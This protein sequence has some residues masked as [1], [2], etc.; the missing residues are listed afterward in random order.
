MGRPAEGGSS[1]SGIDPQRLWDLINSLKNRAGSD[2][3][4]GAPPLVAGWRSQ[5]RRLGLDTGG[6]AALSRHFGWAQDQLP[7]LRQRHHLAVRAARPYPSAG[8][9]AGVDDGLVD[10]ATPAEAARDALAAVHLAQADPAAL[11]GDRFRQLNALLA[12]HQDNPAFAEQFATGLGPAATLAFYTAVT[13]PRQYEDGPRGHPRPSPDLTARRARLADLE[14]ALGATL[15]TASRADTSAMRRWQQD[16]IDLG[17]QDVGDNSQPVHGFQAMSALMRHGEYDAGFLQRYGA[18]L[19]RFEKRNT[20]DEVGGLQHLV[21]RKDVLPWD[22]TGDGV[23]LHYGAANDGGADPMTGFMEALGR[24]PEASTAF[25]TSP[26]HLDYLTESRTWPAD[27]A[28][29]TAKTVAGYAAL[30]HALES[31]TMGAPYDADPPQLHRTAATAAILVALVTRFGRSAAG[32]STKKTRPSGADLLTRE[33]PLTPSLGRITAAY[34]DDVDWALARGDQFSVFAG[35]DGGRESDERALFQTAPLQLFLGTIGH[36]DDAYRSVTN[37]QQAYSTSM[38]HAHLPTTDAIG[39]VIS[40]DAET[41]IR[42]GGQLQGILDHS[43]VDQ[44]KADGDK[45]DENFNKSV[46]E[47]AERQQMIAGLIT[48]GVFAFAPEPEVGVAATIVPLATDIVH[49]Q[50]DGQI[51]QNIAD[52]A[53]SQHR[54]LAD[55]RQGKVSVIYEAGRQAS[56]VPASRLVHGDELHG[57]TDAQR[58]RLDES[59]QSAHSNGYNSGSL[60]QEQAGNLPVTD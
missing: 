24:N 6:L 5:A 40:T 1:F 60:T 30:G 8:H 11:T 48:G 33:A 17:G 49:D 58:S 29:T 12:L 18:A 26:A 9:L 39:G 46:D 35:D 56:W 13:Q 50:I 4:A 20:A 45:T 14:S 38:L 53:E 25:F 22:R 15:A 32:T 47:R 3:A 36:D 16:V 54:S 41:I 34:I 2:A 7:I 42:I 55:V 31:A 10:A 37:A 23:R 52:Y 44:Y 51:E 43:W 57:W 59:L 27:F 28:A 21:L 19:I